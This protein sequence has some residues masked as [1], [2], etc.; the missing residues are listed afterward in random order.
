VRP[1]NRFYLDGSKS[2]LTGDS[3][4]AVEC[5]EKKK[6]AQPLAAVGP[7]NGQACEK[8][9]RYGVFRQAL[10]QFGGGMDKREVARGQRV[11]A[12]YTPLPAGDGDVSR[13]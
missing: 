7:V 2:D 12:Q 3:E 8:K 13:P 1:I 4:A 9:T 10:E 6:P 5:V 11:V